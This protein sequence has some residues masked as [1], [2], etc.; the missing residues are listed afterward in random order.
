MGSHIFA[1]SW[2]LERDLMIT[3]RYDNIM[4]I[5]LPPGQPCQLDQTQIFGDDFEIPTVDSTN[6]CID[7]CNENPK[8]KSLSYFPATGE[9]YLKSTPRGT[10]EEFN[11]EAVSWLKKCTGE[12]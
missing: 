5:F 6:K 4:I 11:P 3:M 10:R 9:C 7:K 8:C 12:I 2:A 1:R